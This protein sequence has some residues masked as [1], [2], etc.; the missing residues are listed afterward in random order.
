MRRLRLVMQEA[1]LRA[2]AR[3]PD[4]PT[5]TLPSPLPL[6]RNRG[7]NGDSASRTRH[8]FRRA[9]TRAL[10]NA[11]GAASA[12][13]PRPSPNGTPTP[14]AGAGAGAGAGVRA[15]T[16]PPTPAD[17][18]AG[19]KAIVAA[20]QGVGEAKG[21]GASGNTGGEDEN[22]ESPRVFNFASVVPTSPDL[23]PAT[24]FD[25]THHA[26]PHVPVKVGATSCRVEPRRCWSRQGCCLVQAQL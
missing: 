3:Q 17:T 24:F 14:I 1:V 22:Q 26:L 6:A 19:G 2:H 8:K 12:L 7:S 18:G 5:R 11:T 9:A 25:A 15:A 16:T 13:E 4:A 21:G 23:D 20:H 10:T